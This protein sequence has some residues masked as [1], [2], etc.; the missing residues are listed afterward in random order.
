MSTSTISAPNTV[1]IGG[2]VQEYL[3]AWEGQQ[4]PIVY[5]TLGEGSPILL[6]PAFST[7][8]TRA[9]MRGLAELLSSQFQVVA[10][11]WP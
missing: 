3:W 7:A 1:G 2:T 9:E 10:L 5:E 4:L 11:D 6:L 8:S